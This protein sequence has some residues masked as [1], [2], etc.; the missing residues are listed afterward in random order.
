MTHHG[1]IGLIT[2]TLLATTPVALA[3]EAHTHGEGVLNIA[4]DSEG[5]LIE[6]AIP[7]DDLVGFEYT[8]SSQREKNAVTDDMEAL[9]AEGL[10]TFNLSN[11]LCSQLSP[12]RF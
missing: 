3:E 1:L 2:S 12:R 10:F 8:P 7:A 6:F 4:I 5:A 9:E 11:E